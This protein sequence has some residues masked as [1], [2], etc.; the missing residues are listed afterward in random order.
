M[1]E[2]NTK[3]EKV[4]NT[5]T[6][7][8]VASNIKEFENMNIDPTC[9]F[10]SVTFVN[11][12]LVHFTKSRKIYYNVYNS[13]ISEMFTV[14]NEALAMIL[15]INHADGVNNT[16]NLIHKLIRKTSKPRYT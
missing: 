11:L 14:T 4:D 1:S 6:L 15:L 9:I 2:E 8:K 5:A 10:F 12:C 16:I 13:S 7:I 3:E